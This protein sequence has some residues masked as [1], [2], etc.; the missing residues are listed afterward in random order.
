MGAGCACKSI[1][2]TCQGSTIAY[3]KNKRCATKEYKVAAEGFKESLLPTVEV[4]EKVRG[5]INDPDIPRKAKVLKEK[6]DEHSITQQDA[7]KDSF[8]IL[9]LYATYGAPSCN[10]LERHQKIVESIKYRSKELD[11]LTTN[12]ASGLAQ[13][14]TVSES[15]AAKIKI[16][17]ALDY[18]LLQRGK[19]EGKAVK[20]LTDAIT[21][22][23]QQNYK[24]PT[25]LNSLAVNADVALLNENRLEYQADDTDAFKLRF[26][27]ED[28]VLGTKDDKFYKGSRGNVESN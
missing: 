27:G 24:Y 12:L 9:A 7:L 23:Y 28:C 26:A 6:L 16:K 15:E 1:A 25:S 10:E 13:V 14:Q 3:A 20:N 5:S 22:Y 11:V 2:T 4:L 8:R 17:E 21:K 18:H 19:Q